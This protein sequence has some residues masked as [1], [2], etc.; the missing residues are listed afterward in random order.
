MKIKLLIN[1]TQWSNLI[2]PDEGSASDANAI[3]MNNGLAAYTQ[4]DSMLTF[5]GDKARKA[6][7]L[8]DRVYEDV[9]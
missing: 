4:E 9:K 3:L 5:H 1:N 8:L 2:F 7:K 6:K